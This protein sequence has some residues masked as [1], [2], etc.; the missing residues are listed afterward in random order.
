MSDPRAQEIAVPR[1][2]NYNTHRV[3]L[4]VDK[5]FAFNGQAFPTLTA[6]AKVTGRERHGREIHD[7]VFVATEEPDHVPDNEGRLYRPAEVDL[8]LKPDA[9]VVDASCHLPGINDDFNGTAPDLGAYETGT[10]LAHYGPRDPNILPRGTITGT[11]Q[12]NLRPQA[13][14]ASNE[15]ICYNPRQA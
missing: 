9:P 5:P 1:R 15:D 7:Y 3:R 4:P 12:N 11:L 13:P 2:Q 10:L 6:L 8:R 14:D